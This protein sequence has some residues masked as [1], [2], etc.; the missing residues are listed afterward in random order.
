MDGGGSEK[1]GGAAAAGAARRHGTILSSDSHLS[2]EARLRLYDS[3][4]WRMEV[5]SSTV[6]NMIV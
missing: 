4:R 6:S 1:R 3:Q 2:P 5:T